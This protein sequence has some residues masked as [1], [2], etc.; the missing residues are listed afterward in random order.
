MAALS[1]ADES[2][3]PSAILDASGFFAEPRTGDYQVKVW[4]VAP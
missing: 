2:G 3:A 4:K 1:T